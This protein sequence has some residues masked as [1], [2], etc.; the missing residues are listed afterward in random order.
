MPQPQPTLRDVAAAIGVSIATVSRVANDGPGVAAKT[1]RQVQA[2]IDRL[3]Y[4]PNAAARA[5]RG[6]HGRTG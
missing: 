1:R 4:T 5:L 6:T 2:A 3:G